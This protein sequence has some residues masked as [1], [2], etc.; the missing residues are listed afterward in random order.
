MPTGLTAE[1]PT[2]ERRARP[3]RPLRRECVVRKEGP[4]SSRWPAFAYDL[5]SAGIGLALA[6]PLPVGSAVVVEPWGGARP[7][8]ARVVR[9]AAASDAW[10][11]GCAL[12]EP[13]GDEDLRRWVG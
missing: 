4:H 7:V 3:R 11:H 5:S 1:P 2:L 12:A 6:L 9:T 8:R 13:L 10:L